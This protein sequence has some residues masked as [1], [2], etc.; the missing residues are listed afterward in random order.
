MGSFDLVRDDQ[1]ARNTTDRGATIDA[2]QRK[3][4]LGGDLRHVRNRDTFP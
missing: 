3:V 4:M 2:S 1:G